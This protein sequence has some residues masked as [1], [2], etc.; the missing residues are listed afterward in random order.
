M[1]NIDV[2]IWGLYVAS[3]ILAAIGAGPC[4][5]SYNRQI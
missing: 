5:T 4:Y 2:G 3:L 1:R